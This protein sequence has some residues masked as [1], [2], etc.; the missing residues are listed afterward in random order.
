VVNL[1]KNASEALPQGGTIDVKTCVE[2][3]RVVLKIRDT[4][5]GMSEQNL[6]RLFNPF[7][8][9]KASAGSGFGLAS[10]RKIID[11]CGGEIFAESSQGKGTTFTILLPLAE[12]PP[13]QTSSPAHVSGPLMTILVIDDMEAVLDVLKAGLTR[14]GHVVVTASSG[15]QG[16]DI[17]KEN[18]IDLVICDLGMPRINGWEVGKRI[19]STCE[20]RSIPKTPFILLTGWGGQKTEAEKI[21]ESGVDAVVEKPINIGNVLK[22][23]QDMAEAFLK[24]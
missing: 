17:F 12:L 16:L 19:R 10:S 13:E 22:I 18:P 4:G 7:F 23:I 11:A 24:R 15:E 3:A 9:T 5:I 1:V 14:S 21:A 2:G 6:K 8:T 20:E